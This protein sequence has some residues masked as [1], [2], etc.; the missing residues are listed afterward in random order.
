MKKTIL[1]GIVALMMSS[2]ALNAQVGINN[3]QPAATLDVTMGTNPTAP[4]G[5]IAPRMAGD[6]LQSKDNFYKVQQDGTLV[7]VTAACGAPYGKTADV[8][9]RGYYYYDAYAYNPEGEH[10]LW[11]AF[12]A[13]KSVEWFYMPHFKLPVTNPT[14][15]VTYYYTFNLYNEYYKQFGG[16]NSSTVAGGYVAS[17]GATG[18][19]YIKDP[20]QIEYYVTAYSADV[21]QITQI[22]M[23]G[24]IHYY[25]KPN[26]TQNEDFF[27][28]IIFKV[29]P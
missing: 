11:K 1:A 22:D 4:E 23:D 12:G 16:Y 7:Y 10:G 17:E 3:E 13:T 6:V 8:V 14:P 15:N 20:T 28:N 19:P 27:V 5:I 26:A 29:L 25:V 9:A 18:L 24:T 2:A 21:L